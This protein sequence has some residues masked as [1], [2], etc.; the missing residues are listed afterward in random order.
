[1]TMAGA[2]DAWKGRKSRPC[3]RSPRGCVD[4]A[5][6]P[7]RG[8]GPGNRTDGTSHGLV[9]WVGEKRGSTPWVAQGW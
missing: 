3:N 1:M 9:D 8:R 6:T 4:P 7:S 5:T 2:R